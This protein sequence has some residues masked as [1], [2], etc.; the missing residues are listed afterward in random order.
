MTV[1]ANP[2]PRASGGASPTA[3]PAIPS[4]SRPHLAAGGLA[5]VCFLTG[6]FAASAWSDWLAARHIHALA[7][8]RHRQKVVGL[9]LQREALRH[10]D[11]LPLYGSSEVDRIEGF[12]ARDVFA[13]APTGFRVF[14]VGGPGGLVFTATQSLGALG[15]DLRGRKVVVS[16]SPTMFVLQNNE[17]LTQRYAGNV[18]PLQALTLLVNADLSLDFRRQFARRLLARPSMIEHEHL[19]GELAKALDSGTRPRPAYYALLPLAHLQR[20]LLE[21]EDKILESGHM[22]KYGVPADWEQPEVPRALDWN[23]LVEEATEQF[24]PRARMNPFGLDDQWW[25]QAEAV[26]MAQ[27]NASNDQQF[28]QSLSAADAWIDLEQLFQLLKELDARP[29]ILSMPFHGSFLRFTGVSAAG[30]LAYYTRVRALADKYGVR[31]LVLDDHEADTYFFRDLG[32]HPSPV[33]WAVYDQV[34]DT[35]YHDAL[36]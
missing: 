25:K 31:T 30:S 35:F 7:G 10:D 4:T 14:T 29:L 9:A 17:R 12:H 3:P 8:S 20:K 6:L 1:S 21:V 33:G 36:R 5:L 15:R 26:S 18:F 27:E 16:L 28:V 22:L 34:L 13:D 2:G 32:S 23:A 11:L 24:R 19:I